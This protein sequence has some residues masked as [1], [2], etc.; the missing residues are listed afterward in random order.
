MNQTA[1]LVIIARVVAT[2]LGQVQT[3]GN[4]V[5][6]YEKGVVRQHEALLKED[7]KQVGI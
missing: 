4:R 6:T 1:D 7:F 3:N 2:A 5:N